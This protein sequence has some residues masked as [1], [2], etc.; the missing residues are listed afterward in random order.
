MGGSN[1]LLAP[2]NGNK[3]TCA[4]EVLTLTSNGD[5]FLEF[6][7]ILVNRWFKLSC[8]RKCQ[9]RLHWAKEWVNID[10]MSYIDYLKKVMGDKLKKFRELIPPESFV[11]F[12]N[13]TLDKLFSV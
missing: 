4:I 11:V 6:A 13:P 7:G 12:S 9:F 1:A 5:E 2:E 3:Y 10:G 8:E